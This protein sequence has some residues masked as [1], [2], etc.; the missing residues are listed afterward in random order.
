MLRKQFLPIFLGIFVVPICHAQIVQ[1][2]FGGGIG[3]APAG[4]NSPLY[5]IEFGDDLA[6]RRW[7]TQAEVGVDSADDQ[8]I[9]TGYTLRAHTLVMFQAT[10]SWR[11]GGGIHY[12][13]LATSKYIKHNRW[14]VIAAMYESGWFRGTFKYLLPGSDPDYNS[15]GPLCEMRF[16]IADGFYFRERIAAFAFRNPYGGDSHYHPGAEA[17]I[18]LMYVFRDGN[19]R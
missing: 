7:F 5:H 11:F 2:Y 3:L 18:G 14:P 12:S 4:F 9:R 8:Q 10:P 16:H 15:T 6:L 19:V 1:P 13:E 17:D